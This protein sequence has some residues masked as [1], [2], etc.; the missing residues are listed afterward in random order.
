VVRRFR[1][2]NIIHLFT[3]KTA[4]DIKNIETLQVK[5]KGKIYS[6]EY[7]TVTEFPYVLKE[8]RVQNPFLTPIT[9]I[10][11]NMAA[12]TLSSKARY[13]QLIEE[14]GF[15]IGT[16]KMEKIDPRYVVKNESS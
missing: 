16:E 6:G 5:L 11:F 4:F 2:N 1:R 15:N 8:I 14:Y 13:R 7:K 9:S 12:E 10:G 3:S